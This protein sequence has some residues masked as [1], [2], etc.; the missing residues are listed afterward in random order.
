[1]ENI[2]CKAELQDAIQMLEAE[3]AI[4]LKLMREDFHQIYESLKPANLIEN[5]LKDIAASP[6]LANNL[7][8]ASVGLA[9]GYLSKIAVTNRSSNKLKKFLGAFLQFGITNIIAQNPKAV[10]SF[11][12]YISHHIFQKEK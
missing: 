1:M 7:L 9:A 11:V 3:Q 10:K 6:Y 12:Q 8:S 5:T 2:S 4:K